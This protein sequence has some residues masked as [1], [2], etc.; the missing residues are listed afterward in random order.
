MILSKE[1][2]VSI[3]NQ[4]EQEEII[5]DN[6]NKTMNKLNPD[7]YNQFYPLDKSHDTILKLLSKIFDLEEYDYGTDIDYYIYE[8][9][10]GKR[11][12][13]FKFDD[14]GKTWVLNSPEILYDYIIATKEYGN[15]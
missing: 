5:Q 13:E 4:L 7:F 1:E 11:A 6:L 12:E 9:E 8:L 2:F 15:G 14:L 3:I 10:Y